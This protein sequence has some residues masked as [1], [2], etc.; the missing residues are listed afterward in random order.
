VSWYGCAPPRSVGAPLDAHA[1]RTETSIM[2]ALA[3]EVVRL[4]L[5]RAGNTAPLAELLTAMRAGSVRAVTGN[6]VLGDPTGATPEEGRVLLEAMADALVAF[7][8]G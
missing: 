1:G 4:D 2:L 6:G 3:P 5:A 7:L 8:V